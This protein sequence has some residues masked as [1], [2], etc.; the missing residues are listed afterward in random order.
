MH[1]DNQH[2]YGF[3]VDADDFFNYDERLHPEMYEIFKNRRVSFLNLLSSL[4]KSEFL[5]SF[6][7]SCNFL[8][9]LRWLNVFEILFQFIIILFQLWEQRYINP[10]YYEALKSS[11]IPQPCPDVYN[12]PLMS[13]DFTKELVEEVEHYGHWS[14][15]K[16][17]VNFVF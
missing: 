6:K 1:V 13:E 4:K 12:Y 8:Q 7:N 3:L 15:E 16:N 5:Y 10:K 11:D 14:S 2:Y 17:E 9:K